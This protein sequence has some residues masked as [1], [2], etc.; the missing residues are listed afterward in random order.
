MVHPPDSLLGSGCCSRSDDLGNA[1][2]ADAAGADLDRTNDALVEGFYLLEIG[3]P[4]FFGF[5]V[6]VADVVAS[7]RLFSADGT[8]SRHNALPPGYL[9]RALLA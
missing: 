8:D 1:A 6:S 5:V 9:E 2:T 3:I 4:D 7:R